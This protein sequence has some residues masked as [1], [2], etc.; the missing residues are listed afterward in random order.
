[1]GRV[2]VLL[3]A[4]NAADLVQRHVYVVL[5]SGVVPKEDNYAVVE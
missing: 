5:P 2:L 4:N 1:M 3:R